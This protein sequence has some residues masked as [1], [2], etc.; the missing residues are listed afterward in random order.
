MGVLGQHRA[1]SDKARLSCISFF[2]KF[3]RLLVGA[4][5]R[6]DV[7]FRVPRLMYLLPQGSGYLD[8]R[9]ATI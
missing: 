4:G 7:G 3:F 8:S 1:K 9:I 6:T 2:A 5:L